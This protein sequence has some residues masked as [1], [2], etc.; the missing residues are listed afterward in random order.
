MEA[1]VLLN[2]SI[3]ALKNRALK[4]DDK[5]SE[6]EIEI[7]NYRSEL[8]ECLIRIENLTN[9]IEKLK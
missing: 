3:E 9:A 5:I 8:E 4:C 2:Q 1:I 6:L 7:I